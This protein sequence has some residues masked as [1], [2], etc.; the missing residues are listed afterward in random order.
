MADAASRMLAGR[1]KKITA[2]G[3]AYKDALT[4][5][6][7]FTKHQRNLIAALK[8][9]NRETDVAAKKVGLLSRAYQGVTGTIKKYGIEI[10]G[11]AAATQLLR[12]EQR[13]TAKGIEHFYRTADKLPTQL[14][15]TGSHFENMGKTGSKAYGHVGDALNNLVSGEFTKSWKDVKK[16]TGEGG[17]IDTFLGTKGAMGAVMTSRRF[18][19]AVAKDAH[20]LA[21]AYNVPAEAVRDL[22][23]ELK[24]TMRSGTRNTKEYQNELKAVADR[25][26]FAEKALGVDKADA[27]AFVNRSM[28]E[29]GETA[30]T[31]GKR[32][33]NLNNYVEVSNELLQ[34]QGKLSKGA[35]AQWKDDY[36]KAVLEASS[37]SKHL[38]LNTDKLAEAMMASAHSAHK[39]GLSYNQVQRTMKAIPQ[40]LGNTPEFMQ[41]RMGGAFLKMVNDGEKFEKFLEGMP[42]KKADNIRASVKNIKKYG[43]NVLTKRGALFELLGGTEGGMKMAFKEI[44]NLGTDSARAELL[45][46]MFGI[47]DRMTAINVLATLEEG[48]GGLEEFT[49]KVK[50]AKGKEG[51]A[52]DKAFKDQKKGLGVLTTAEDAL[53]KLKRHLDEISENRM[54]LGAAA[55]T[56]GFTGLFKRLFGGGAASAAGGLLPGGGG[57]GGGAMALAGGGGGGG[58]MRSL[59]GMGAAFLASGVT[60]GKFALGAA[61]GGG[62]GLIANVLG[63]VG[64]AGVALKAGAA[65]AA[66]FAALAGTLLVSERIARRIAKTDKSILEWREESQRVEEAIAKREKKDIEA[67]ELKVTK[68]P[69]RKD[70]LSRGLRAVTGGLWDR[71]FENVVA[72]GGTAARKDMLDQITGGM[73]SDLEGKSASDL[74]KMRYNGKSPIGLMWG[75][76]DLAA[77]I[78]K[79]LQAKGASPEAIEGALKLRAARTGASLKSLKH[80][81]AAAKGETIAERAKSKSKREDEAALAAADRMLAER[82]AQAATPVAGGEEVAID[83]GQRFMDER[84]TADLSS[85]IAP[86]PGGIATLMNEAKLGAATK[87]NPEVLRNL[88]GRDKMAAMVPSAARGNQTTRAPR[89]GD[90]P[91]NAGVDNMGK[92]T[93]TLDNFY[94]LLGNY[95]AAKESQLPFGTGVPR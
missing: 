43:G 60:A 91:L 71:R 39:A 9:G 55:A 76:P 82:S 14:N 1:A 20:S 79:A 56:G 77:D 87:I 50:E 33:T 15:R 40:M 68:G 84:R 23:R 48:G 12:L 78:S 70:L 41:Q 63:L 49:K 94:D 3:A 32:L 89:V 95:D 28:W 57:G 72:S 69:Q 24:M 6:K 25:I 45:H 42:K 86:A 26:L 88:I 62:G 47:E 80:R 61:M 4:S 10:S 11:A 2:V 8:G 65:L 64:K 34:K 66:P 16:M 13:D 90:I 35:T 75:R 51:T 37:A 83:A 54:L 52:W 30:E 67:G 59:G 81:I 53:G 58:I 73:P 21:Q 46:K 5:Q 36:A 93:L 74:D 27:V 38:F 22:Q 31:A 17:L 7:E 19:V 44:K 18:A 85:A 29:F 92:L